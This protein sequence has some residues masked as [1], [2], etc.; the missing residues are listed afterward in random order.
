MIAS[1][2]GSG[3]F[4]LVTNFG[5]WVCLET[6][7][8]TS[9]G[10]MECYGAGLPFLRN[11]LLGDL[12]YAGLLFGGLHLAERRFLSLREPTLVPIPA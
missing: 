2:L 5:V 11:G 9:A 7:P 1:L 4:F 10:L 8:K 3:L 6:Y 12:F